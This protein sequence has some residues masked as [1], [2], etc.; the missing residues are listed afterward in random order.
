MTYVDERQGKAATV[1]DCWLVLC[2]R[3]G[4]EAVKRHPLTTATEESGE[5]EARSAASAWEDGRG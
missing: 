4:E 5:A 3:R 1:V 2:F